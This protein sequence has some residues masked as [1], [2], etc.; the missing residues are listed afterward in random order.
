MSRT[1]LHREVPPSFAFKDGAGA[2]HL[3]FGARADKMLPS[4]P[5]VYAMTR[6]EPI[7]QRW[8]ILYVGKAQCMRSRFFDHHKIEA[9]RGFRLTHVHFSIEHDAYRRSWIEADM[10]WGLAPPLNARRPMVG[11]WL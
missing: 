11:P 3:F 6:W 8:A 2:V 7:L 10:I 1:F 5:T 9:A 4:V